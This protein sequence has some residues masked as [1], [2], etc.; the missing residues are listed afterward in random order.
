MT[1][2]KG[3]NADYAK[4][5]IESILNQSV[6]TNDFVIVCDGPLTDKLNEML[7]KFKDANNCIKLVELEENVGLGAALRIGVEEC[8]NSIIARMDNDD[9]AKLNRCELELEEFKKNSDLAICGSFMNEFEYDNQ[10]PIRMKKV[11]IEYEDIK[12]YSKRRNPF[13]HSTVM[14]KKECILNVGNY[15]SMRTNQDVDLW[16]RALNNGLKGINIPLALV[17][18]R[19]DDDTY[20]RRKD[21][22]NVKLLIETWKNFYNNKYCS[23]LDLFYVFVTQIAIFIIPTWLLKW[24]YDH[25]R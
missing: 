5:S 16:V 14:F 25:L 8:K 7:Y 21:W 4:L 23:F 6:K 3:D 18:F 1:I 15:S 10:T 22:K 12:R 17:D 9:I 13:N 24:S 11:P 2:Y 20:K 19:F